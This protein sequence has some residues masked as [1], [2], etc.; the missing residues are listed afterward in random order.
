MSF[1]LLSPLT[2]GTPEGR[3]F[4]IATDLSAHSIFALITFTVLFCSFPPL[5][6]HFFRFASFSLLKFP[7][8]TGGHFGG[9]IPEHRTSRTTRHEVNSEKMSYLYRHSSRRSSPF[10][11]C[12]AVYRGDDPWFGRDKAYHFAVSGAIGAGTTLA[13]CRNGASES[14]APVIGMSAAVGIG[15]GKECYDKRVKGLHRFSLPHCFVLSPSTNFNNPPL[16]AP[17]NR[18]IPLVFRPFLAVFQTNCYQ[19]R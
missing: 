5:Y 7:I 16:P 17:P 4:I 15:A 9:F 19:N 1:S 11:G 18:L 3:G 6:P 2:R 10:S 8:F 14:G 13:A 12:A